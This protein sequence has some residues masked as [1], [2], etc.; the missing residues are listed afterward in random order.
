MYRSRR[1]WQDIA[2]LSACPVLVVLAA[3]LCISG[4]QQF[5][6]V[7]VNRCAGRVFQ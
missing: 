4:L 6:I 5:C 3:W 7:T 1:K 2:G